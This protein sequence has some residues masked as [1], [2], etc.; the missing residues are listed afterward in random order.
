MVEEFIK[1]KKK[2]NNNNNKTYNLDCKNVGD[3]K[4]K[5]KNEIDKNNKNNNNNNDINNNLK[6]NNNIIDKLFILEM[7]LIGNKTDKSN[8]Y[9]YKNIM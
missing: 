1:N 6:N 4:D 8:N 5:D 9:C 7:N 2:E 3:M